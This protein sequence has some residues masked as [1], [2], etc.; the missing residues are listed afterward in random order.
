VAASRVTGKTTRARMLAAAVGLILQLSA[1]AAAITGIAMLGPQLA[2]ASDPGHRPHD[3]RR[4]CDLLKA[5][6][7]TVTT[8]GRADQL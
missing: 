3:G 5:R 4:E 7:E 2:A 6:A 8:E 1:A